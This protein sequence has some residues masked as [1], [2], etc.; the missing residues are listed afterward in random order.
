MVYFAESPDTK[1]FVFCYPEGSLQP[2]TPLLEEVFGRAEKDFSCRL[3]RGFGAIC[4]EFSRLRESYETGR[5]QLLH[6]RYLSGDPGE[7]GA[8]EWGRALEQRLGAVVEEE[9]RADGDLEEA[10]LRILREAE[11]GAGDPAERRARYRQAQ[12]LMLE[13]LIVEEDVLSS[14]PLL[15]EG[16]PDG[17]EQEEFL[18]FC[19]RALAV[20]RE[21]A[22]KKQFRY[23]EEGKAFMRENYRNSL[24]SVSDISEHVGISMAYYS[25]LFNELTHESVT[26]YLNTIR[27]EQAKRLLSATLITVQEVGFRCG[28]NSA[29]AFRRV[30]KKITGLSPSQYRDTYYDAEK[31]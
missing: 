7:K 19:R 23:V 1:V 15:K 29:D 24:L 12:D 27:V 26:S 18:E 30:F 31:A 14:L 2:V 6:S 10:A 22:G 28:F 8:S 21:L 17:K 4:R 13:K 9:L 5:E 20:G 3:Y 16:E 11:Y 25:S